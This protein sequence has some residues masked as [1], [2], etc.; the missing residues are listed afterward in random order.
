MTGVTGDG[1]DLTPGVLRRL[2]CDAE[3]IPV[4]YGSRGEVLDVGRT[5]AAPSP[6]RS[7]TPWSPATDTAPS[8]PA[9]AHR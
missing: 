3:I 4:V 6:F 5:I 1:L 9:P 7:G 8:P 2:A